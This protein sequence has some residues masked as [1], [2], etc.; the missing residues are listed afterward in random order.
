L[1]SGLR[2]GFKTEAEVLARELREELGLSYS[3]P[4]DCFALAEHFGIPVVALSVSARQE[5]RFSDWRMS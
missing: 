4:L 2:Y 1:A 3:D 5:A